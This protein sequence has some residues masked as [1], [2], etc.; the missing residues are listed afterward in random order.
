M[1]RAMRVALLVALVAACGSGDRPVRGPDAPATNAQP[2]KLVVLMVIDQW[3]AWAFEQKRPAL[4]HGFDR[5]LR[6]GEWHR[7]QHPSPATLTAP[8]HAL[9]GTGEPPSASGILANEWWHRDVEK[10]VK[11]VEDVDGS[12]TTRWL[13]VPGLGDAVAAAKTGAKAVSVSLKDRA[14]ILPLG[15]AGTPIWIDKAAAR[16]TSLQP[17]PWLDAYNRAH[18]ISAHFTDVWTPLDPER[19]AKLSG[20]VDAAPGEV[21]ENGLGPTFPHA[22]SATKSPID[23]LF[24]MPVGNELVLETALAAIDGEQLGDNRV[25]D[26]LVVSLS[27]HDYVGHGW[28]HESWE[29]WDM[30]L[31]LDEL[32]DAFLNALDRRVGAGRWALLVTS[33]HGASPLPERLNGGRITYESLRDA[34]NRAAIAELGPGDW[35]AS[36]K[37]PNVFLTAKA[38]ATPPKDRAVLLQK[39][40]FALRSFPGIAR[41][42]RS[43]EFAGHCDQR[44]GDAFAFCSMLDPEGWILEDADEAFATAHGS[45]N[46]YDRIVPVIMLP[47]NRVPHAALAAP[48]NAMIYMVRISTVIAHWLGVTSPVS[49]PRK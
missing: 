8:G 16:W 13:R 40:I 1:M 47:P 23:A 26:L 32:L 41:A 6:E 49:L 44:T 37:Y 38:N 43:D 22:A 46:D 48:D 7:G 42:E 34:A 30:T 18:P 31:R 12:I 9:L 45:F 35:I 4:T 5:L 17:L 24:A 28:G 27:A 21:G 39:I 33:D 19:L 2:P 14:A 10:M 29:M 36:A 15:H 20:V 11:A 3:P 25:T